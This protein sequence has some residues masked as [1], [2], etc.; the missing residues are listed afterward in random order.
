MQPLAKLIS[1]QE[2]EA[3]DELGCGRNE[4]VFRCVSGGPKGWF[5]Y[6]TIAVWD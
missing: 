5:F 4:L 6:V 2:L 1:D 3:M